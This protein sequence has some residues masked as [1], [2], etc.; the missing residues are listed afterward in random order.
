MR[1]WE[2]AG[3]ALGRQTEALLALFDELG[4][5]ATFF[6]LGVAARAHPRL[7]EAIADAGH[8]IGSHGD[9][10]LPVYSQSP[11]EFAADLMRSRWT[12]AELTGRQ[13]AGY[14]APAF[15]ITDETPWV[16]DVLAEQ[17]FAYDASRHDAPRLRGRARP[18]GAAPH[19]L[20]NGLWELPV[21]VWRI[22]RA[23]IPVGGASYWALLPTPVV[24]RGLHRAGPWAG[25]YLHPHELDPEPLDPRL[26]PEAS[27]GQR[28]H[29]AL[30]AA[31]RNSARRRAPG[32]LRAI[33]QRFRLIPYGEGYA[34][35]RDGVGA[36]PQP[37]P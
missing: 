15:S 2:A 1:D 29:G 17:G 35:L 6:V 28:V 7:L 16:H 4:A 23:A 24:I 5:R 25:L 27:L 18:A 20:G 30:R 19:R 12:I 8:E 10:H 13:P 3:P 31:Q 14:R 21:A 32:M 26:A 37:I 11:E 9:Q 36:R 22:G 34:Q 33:A